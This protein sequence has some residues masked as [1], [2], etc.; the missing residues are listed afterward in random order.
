M[1]KLEMPKEDVSFEWRIFTFCLLIVVGGGGIWAYNV[2]NDSGY[3]PHTRTVDLYMRGEWLQSE[4][5]TCVG[6]PKWST[7]NDEVK[8]ASLNCVPD[9]LE[10]LQ[11]H[12]IPVHFWGRIDRP[13]M[14]QGT[15]KVGREFT[16]RCT[17]KSDD[18]TC[19]AIN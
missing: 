14:K 3:I 19:Y 13:G 11:P 1:P 2:A 9:S 18:F 12:N 7:L 6:F 17:R 16:W 4:N 5:K 8:L 10:G 15:L